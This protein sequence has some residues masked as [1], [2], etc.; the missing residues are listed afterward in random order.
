MSGV[1]FPPCRP[2]DHGTMG[3]DG[4]T[5]V[6]IPRKEVKRQKRETI[7]GDLKFITR[8]TEFVAALQKMQNDHYAQNLSNLT[9]P[10]IVVM[11]GIKNVRVVRSEP[12]TRSVYCF[13][14]KETGHILK[15]AGWNAPAKH[16]RGNIH[17]ENMLDGCN[18]YGV[19]YL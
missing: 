18:P 13:I 7:T 10:T 8:L 2:E 14:E 1:P 17:N 3:E 11:N 12:H 15:P 19:R 6:Y 16:P 5:R 9:P 4:E